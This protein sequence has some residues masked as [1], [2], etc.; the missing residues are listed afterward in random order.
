MLFKSTPSLVSAAAVLL[1]TTACSAGEAENT[2]ANIDP[3]ENRVAITASSESKPANTA[4]TDGADDRPVRI[5]TEQD[6]NALKMA[7]GA[8]K[9]S[10]FKQFLRAFS[11]SWLVQERYTASRVDF[12]TVGSSR[13]MPMRQYLDQNNF[14]FAPMDNSYV[15]AESARFFDSDP[16]ANWR[17]LVFV[18]LEFNTS[19]GNRQRVD[20]VSGVFER[21]LDPPPSD[22]EEGLGELLQPG[23]SGYVL[24]EPTVSCWQLTQDVNNPPE[25]P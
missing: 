15:T 18:Q 2:H 23:S 13:A 9:A 22:L 6:K 8:C 25:Q 17:K 10:D 16:D 4:G 14:P 7:E 20:W 1:S 12:G 24:F 21:N 11:A 3:A 19:S 5:S